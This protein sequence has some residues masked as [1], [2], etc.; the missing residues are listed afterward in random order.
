VKNAPNVALPPL[1]ASASQSGP[2]GNK[3]TRP[4]QAEGVDADKH[5][6]PERTTIGSKC[7]RLSKSIGE[8]ES[9][10]HNEIRLLH[11]AARTGCESAHRLSERIIP[12]LQSSLD[13]EDNDE[14]WSG[15]RSAR[16]QE[17]LDVIFQEFLAPIAFA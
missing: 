12:V 10:R 13:K 8:H 4:D 5:R 9:A 14:K 3:D 11:P 2:V 15:Y 17:L 1:R 16:K 6:C 7:G